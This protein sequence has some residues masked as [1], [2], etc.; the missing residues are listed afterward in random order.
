VLTNEEIIQNKVTVVNKTGLASA[1][2]LS[3]LESAM[4]TESV[5]TPDIFH[6]SGTGSMELL[7]E[8]SGTTTSLV[9]AYEGNQHFDLEVTIRDV[10]TRPVGLDQRKYFAGHVQPSR[11]ITVGNVMEFGVAETGIWINT[12]ETNHRLTPIN[13]N[14]I[15]YRKQ[16]KAHSVTP[17]VAIKTTNVNF[18]A[19]LN[20]CKGDTF[21]IVSKDNRIG[22]YN[23]GVG[24]DQK[25][26][27]LPSSEKYNSAHMAGVDHLVIFNSLYRRKQSCMGAINK[28]S[29]LGDVDIVEYGIIEGRVYVMIEGEDY[30]ARLT[31]HSVSGLNTEVEIPAARTKK[32][33]K[34]SAT[35]AI[36]EYL[37]ISDVSIEPLPEVEPINFTAE[38]HARLNVWERAHE[39][40]CVSRDQRYSNSRAVWFSHYSM[41]L[42]RRGEAPDEL[43]VTIMSKV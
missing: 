36:S 10:T 23:N 13:D 41:M 12:P 4:R 5:Q 17:S 34:R 2:T 6:G 28:L 25:I 26:T 19:L 8:E 35:R 24:E 40:W 32:Q 33:P 14:G 22:I 30:S 31:Y 11:H 1:A 15:C 9:L 43:D 42:I 3:L 18:R 37:E 39:E 38:E 16:Y 21:C 27:P 20:K 7:V 29:L